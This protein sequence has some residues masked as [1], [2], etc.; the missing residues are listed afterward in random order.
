MSKRRK[1]CV[2][3]L[4]SVLS[5]FLIMLIYKIG[6]IGLIMILATVV[7]GAA[8]IY[9]SGE[10]LT[11]KRKKDIKSLDQLIKMNPYQ[12]ESYIGDYF[13]DQG[14][15]VHQTA[16]SNDG[17]KDLILHKGGKTYYVECKKYAR[18]NSIGRPLIQKLVGAAHP[19]GAKAI[20]VTTSK[21]TNGAVAE[22]KRSNV[23][24]IDGNRLM[25][26]LK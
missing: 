2:G 22:A 26:M 3:Y 7:I 5:L 25:R 19:T 21:F 23:Q 17:G 6:G 11:F 12:F 16:K 4:Y 9:L 14:Y 10:T 18:S 1:P 24:L 13:R 20:F 8:A 15:T